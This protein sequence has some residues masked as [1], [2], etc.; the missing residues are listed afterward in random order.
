MAK[1]LII[2]DDFDQLRVA[3]SKMINPD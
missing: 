3:V 1:Q 2:S